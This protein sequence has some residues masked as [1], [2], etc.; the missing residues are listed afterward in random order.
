MSLVY[1]KVLVRRYRAVLYLTPDEDSEFLYVSES[2]RKELL[3]PRPVDTCYLKTRDYSEAENVFYRN[4]QWVQ[5]DLLHVE[6][7]RDPIEIEE[8]LN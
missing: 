8:D 3:Q 6:I 1:N 4:R 7:D 2:K 5:T